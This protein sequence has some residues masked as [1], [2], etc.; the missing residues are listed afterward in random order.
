MIKIKNHHELIITRLL[1]LYISDIMCTL[2]L[3]N[4]L[5]DHTLED[6]HK[7][8]VNQYLEQNSNALAGHLLTDLQTLT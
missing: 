6:V 1:I 4:E 7:T 3:Y 5:M 8:T 2:E